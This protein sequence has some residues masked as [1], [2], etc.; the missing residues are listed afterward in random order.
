MTHYL[1]PVLTLDRYSDY[2]NEQVE[3]QLMIQRN[4]AIEA[5]F[6]GQMSADDLLDLLE[7]QGID[8]DLYVEYTIDNLNYTI[9]HQI[10]IEGLDPAIFLL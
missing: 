8:P 5:C 4:Q 9:K 6:H 2:C 10:E 3:T 1:M 7:F